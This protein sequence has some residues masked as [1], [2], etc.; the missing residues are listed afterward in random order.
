MKILY[1][2]QYFTTPEYS[3]GT[4]SYEVAK[5]LVKRGHE[6]RMVTS[7]AFLGESAKKKRGWNCFV[8]DGIQV[9][10][11]NLGYSNSLGFIARLRVFLWFMVASSLRGIAQPVDLVFATSTPLTIAVPG[12]FASI[13]RRAPMVFEV[14]DLWPAA[15][16]A[17]GVLKN[18]VLIWLAR[19]LERRAYWHSSAIVAL[20][21]PMLEGVR[22]IVGDNVPK[23]MSPNACDVDL[24]QGVRPLDSGEEPWR[25]LT[26]GRRFLAY[27]GSL[28]PLHGV[29][30]LVELAGELKR[31]GA[32]VVILCAGEGSEQHK[33][34]E[35]AKRLNVLDSKIFFLGVLSK[36]EVVGL[37]REAEM[38]FATGLPGNQASEMA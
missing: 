37:F 27:A 21:P 23:L 19:L 11:L 35:R 16:I 2:H 25:E 9:E 7:S 17:M 29:D 8:V 12:I 18:P 15:P 28:G 5:R 6:V 26:R 1:L 4:R 24:F 20:S 33:L 3:G 32:D 22:K 13:C 34:K 14:R 36:V 38:I 10:A 30:F 31:N